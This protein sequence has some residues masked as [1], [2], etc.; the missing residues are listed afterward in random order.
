MS[1]DMGDTWLGRFMVTHALVT[2]RAL[3]DRN[4]PETTIPRVATPPPSVEPLHAVGVASSEV[5]EGG[6]C[7][8]G[9][10]RGLG[11]RTKRVGEMRKEEEGEKEIRARGSGW[12]S[13]MGCS[14]E[15][16]VKLKK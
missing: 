1:I 14:H 9:R 4:V 12:S 7:R 3:E 6:R 11:R 16:V 10:R 2:F 5:D 8:I 15:T 13:P